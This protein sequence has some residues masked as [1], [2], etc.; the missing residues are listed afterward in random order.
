MNNYLNRYFK[1]ILIGTGTI[2]G[3]MTAGMTYNCLEYLY[4]SNF[5][6]D[7]K[8]YYSLIGHPHREIIPVLMCF[9]GACTGGYLTYKKLK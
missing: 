3:S 9:T 4:F 2:M 5:V 8:A 1:F 6:R 7:K